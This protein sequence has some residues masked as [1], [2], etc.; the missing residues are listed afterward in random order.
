MSTQTEDFIHEH[1][2]SWAETIAEWLEVEDHYVS[3][4]REES[5]DFEED[6]E[7]FSYDSVLEVV[8]VGDSDLIAVFTVGGPHVEYSTRGNELT[9]RMGGQSG[10]IY[11]P[12]AF[13]DLV[14]STF[15]DY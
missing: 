1:L 14:L 12:L 3:G 13:R 8:N 15:V 7:K 6:E 9:V 11:P 4:E 5:P 10:T 2:A